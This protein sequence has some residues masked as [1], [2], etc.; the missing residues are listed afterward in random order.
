MLPPGTWGSG[1]WELWLPQILPSTL[2]SSSLNWVPHTGRGSQRCS[3]TG[4]GG[5]RP[6]FQ[7]ALL[8]GTLPGPPE[9][10]GVPPKVMSVS[11]R[12]LRV[13]RPR[14]GAQGDPCGI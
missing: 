1:G 5:L 2:M 8:R 14:A 13:T 4:G 10:T 6:A 3:S 7:P 11:T 12:S 9:M